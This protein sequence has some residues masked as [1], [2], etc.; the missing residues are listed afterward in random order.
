V[1]LKDATFAYDGGAD[2]F[3]DANVEI[4]RQ[5]KVAIVGAN[6]AGKTTLL[7]VL[8][9]QLA[10][11]AGARESYPHTRM[12]YFAQH[13]AETLDGSL[14]V[15]G[16]LEQV[17]PAPWRPRLRSLL[18]N[19]LFT[20]D[21]VFKLCRVLSGGERQRVA[22]ARLLMEP[23]NLLLLDEP[24]HHL[25]LAGKEVLEDA[26]EQ[27]PGAVAVVTHDRSLMARIASRVIEVNAGRV[28]LY[29]GGYDD[30][31][32][33]RLAR[34]EEARRTTSSG[35]GREANAAPAAAARAGGGSPPAAKATTDDAA[36][37]PKRAAGGGGTARRGGR[38]Q[39]REVSRLTREIETREQRVRVLEGQL[40]DPDVYHDGARAR[41]LVAE[42]ERLRAELESLWQR[43]GEL[44]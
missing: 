14:T 4:D 22:L 39:D 37:V 43:M 42:Y 3:R 5:D 1:R 15:L 36:R 25:D 11:R 40:A 38:P 12:G 6:G 29:P 41:D 8:A 13:A 16:A 18:G 28:V 20:G 32:T 24:T 23:T 17:A 19:F 10:A 30:Y 33:T 2:V 34:D 27:Y 35:H 31:E 7:R 26:L 21:D 9:G 44:I